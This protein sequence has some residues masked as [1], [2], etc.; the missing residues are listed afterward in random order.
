[1]NRFD[2]INL[3]ILFAIYLAVMICSPIIGAV[4]FF[5]PIY[6]FFALMGWEFSNLG[7]L[8]TFFWGVL[9][10]VFVVTPGFVALLVIKLVRKRS[11]SEP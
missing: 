11:R 6:P 5:F 1:M 8:A 9:F 3:P 10:D 4:L 7:P 2:Q